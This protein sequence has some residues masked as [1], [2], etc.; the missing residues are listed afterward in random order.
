MEKITIPTQ[1]NFDVSFYLA[2]FHKRLLAWVVDMAILFAYYMVT[3]F[4]L[5]TLFTIKPSKGSIETSYNIHWS[6]LIVASPLLVYH[7]VMEWMLNGQSIG[8][9]LLKIK[10]ISANGMQPAL[11]QYLLR[12]LLRLVD[13]GITSGMGAL[14]SIVV[15]KKAQRIGDVLANTIVISTQTVANINH[16][17]FLDIEDDYKPIYKNV[18][19]LSD[20]DMNIIRNVLERAKAKNN[21]VVAYN[22][23]QKI[24][25]VLQIKYTEA[26]NIQF[27]ETILK[28]YNYLSEQ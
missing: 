22:T 11:H 27:L 2:P 6:Q 13:I 14:V 19:L 8:K 15:T 9:K 10:V 20:R 4:I 23:A 21:E 3:M 5:E 7:F 16:T 17:V 1:F 26:S 28:D 25:E 18:L 24:R 12:W